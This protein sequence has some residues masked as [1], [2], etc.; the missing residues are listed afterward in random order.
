M[1]L[2]D[3]AQARPEDIACLDDLGHQVR[4]RSF[5]AS[6]ASLRLLYDRAELDAVPERIRRGGCGERA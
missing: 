2:S 6:R 5:R 3:R 4:R 1:G